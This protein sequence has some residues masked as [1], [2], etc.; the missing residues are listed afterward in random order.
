MT[1]QECCKTEHLVEKLPVEI[2]VKGQEEERGKQRSLG[3]LQIPDLQKSSNRPRIQATR[4]FTW[5][6]QSWKLFPCFCH[7]LSFS[8]KSLAV[9]LSGASQ[10]TKKLL[11]KETSF[12]E[13]RNHYGPHL[14]E[15]KEFLWHRISRNTSILIRPKGRA[16][17]EAAV[18]FGSKILLKI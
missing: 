15:E 2:S 13:S 8:V 17:R 3:K 1:L 4:S 18:S 12:L 10:Q 16:S 9:N 11:R 6:D 14:R 5:E 7:P